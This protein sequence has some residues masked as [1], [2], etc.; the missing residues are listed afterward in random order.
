M[1]QSYSYGD[2][3][4]K[5]KAA[6]YNYGALENSVV[7]NPSLLSSRVAASRN[8]FDAN[9]PP[10]SKIENAGLKTVLDAP[11]DFGIG[12]EKAVGLDPMRPIA[13]I[14]A[15]LSG[16]ASGL[17]NLVTHP[18]ETAKNIGGSLMDAVK[19]GSA[20][21]DAGN[22]PEAFQ[23][24]GEMYGMAKPVT[25]GI[26]AV[27][28]KVIPSTARAGLKFERVMN[29]AK[30]APIDTSSAED[31][32]SRAQELR[33]R[34]S[35]MPK[36][37]NDFAKNRT[38]A[39]GDFMGVPVTDPMT[40]E[41]GRDFASNAGRLSARETMAANPQMQRQVAQFS[42]AM[43]TANR[44]AAASVGMGDLYDS[45]MKEY[46]QAKT[47]QDMGDVI[48]KWAGRIALGGVGYELWKS[49]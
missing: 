47:L 16:A 37:L 31:I 36:V 35:T 13:S 17:G 8:A 40:Y 7:P 23:S 15:A 26:G 4:V 19:R 28:D 11:L 24:A 6:A 9:L 43:K 32:L 48:K 30:D 39:T 14:P 25:E 20:A 44:D 33:Q 29:A 10:E 2:L 18:I 46:R 12:L 34:G 1:P 21:V 27:A 42:N 5:S 41:V 22:I 38:A 45:A 3:E 49:H